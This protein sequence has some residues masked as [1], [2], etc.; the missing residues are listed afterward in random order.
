M[1]VFLEEVSILWAMIALSSR[2]DGPRELVNERWS[3]LRA[4]K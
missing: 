1:S 3:R 2:R 4:L